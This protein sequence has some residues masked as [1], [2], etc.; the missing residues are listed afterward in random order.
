MNVFQLHKIISSYA[1]RATTD[2]DCCFSI[3]RCLVLPRYEFISTCDMLLRHF[4]C[5]L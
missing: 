1:V 2:K 5:A 4:M 3:Y